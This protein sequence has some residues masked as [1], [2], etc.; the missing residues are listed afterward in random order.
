MATFGRDTGSST[1]AEPANTLVC[2]RFQNTAGTG[3]L[4]QLEA[5]FNDTTPT[6]N[7]R[8]GVYADSSGSIGGRLLDAGVVAVAN[9]WVAISGLSLGVTSGTYYWLATIMQS[10]NSMQYQSSAGTNTLCWYNTTYGALPSSFT[11]T[12]YNNNQMVIRATVDVSVGGQYLLETSSVDGYLLEDS[13][14]VLILE[15]T[16]S[17]FVV[18]WAIQ[19]TITIQPGMSHA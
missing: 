12:G 1:S 6:G 19:S 8:M 18:A 7:V 13:G 5:F 2:S 17:G 4:T 14:G 9:G 11:P 16:V 3:N 15:E 10:A